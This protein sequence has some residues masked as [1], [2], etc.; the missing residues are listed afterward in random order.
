MKNIDNSTH[1][2]MTDLM[3]VVLII[4]MLIVVALSLDIHNKI[5]IISREN[6]FSGG[7]TQPL[8]LVSPVKYS[9]REEIAI[10]PQSVFYSGDK[11]ASVM[12]ISPA[13]FANLLSFI[14][15]GEIID[16]GRTLPLINISMYGKDANVNINY[17]DSMSGETGV[18]KPAILTSLL[19]SVWPGYGFGKTPE[20]YFF[21]V[22]KRAKIYFESDESNG[23]KTIV[24][25]HYA[26]DITNTG[27]DNLFIL[28]TLATAITDFIY[29]GAFNMEERFDI[30]KAVEGEEATQY[31]KD[32][33]RHGAGNKA[34]PFVKYAE[35][36]KQFIE[37]RSRLNLTPPEWVETFFLD[38]IGA[39]LKIISTQKHKI[40]LTKNN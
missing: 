13:S 32:W 4:F 37:Y 35:A 29:I 23:Q 34:A 19:Q 39:N 27:T 14:D 11:E 28:N 2:I 22:N 21:K 30:L 5:N 8:M 16:E 33:G 26:I 15:Y 17:F 1:E 3:I 9:S 10:Y 24:I 40:K 20:N 18:L 36:K 31:Y 38:K 7:K 25:G 12:A 6:T